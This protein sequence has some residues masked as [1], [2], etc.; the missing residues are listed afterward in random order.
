MKILTIVTALGKG[1][2][3]RAAQNFALGY[4]KLGNDSRILVIND[5][6]IRYEEIKSEI[7]V[8]KKI[9]HENLIEL[10]KWKLD[11]I[12]IHSHGCHSNEINQ[13]FNWLKKSD[14]I[15]V[16][17]NVFSKPSR[18]ESQLHLSFQ[19][20]DWALKLYRLRNGSVQKS[21]YVPYPV[22]YEGF[23]KADNNS[24]LRFKEKY[25]I[26]FD[27]QIIGRIGQFYD[28]KWSKILI[29]V[30]FEVQKVIPNTTL[31]LVNAPN[32][33]R[34]QSLK[35]K[36]SD[37][38]ILID[39]LEGDEELSIAYS[40][41]DVFC[42]TADQGESF[43]MVITE[44]ILCETPIVVLDTPWADNTQCEIVNNTKSGLI[45]R[46]ANELKK[47]IIA[48]LNKEIIIDTKKARNKTIELFDYLKVAN[49][50]LQYIEK[51]KENLNF[52][53]AKETQMSNYTNK[54][55]LLLLKSKVFTTL[56]FFKADY[57][58]RIKKLIIK[59][60]IS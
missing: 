5:L 34:D 44:S 7:S 39:Q 10:S 24:I 21:L 32:S 47:H 33:I 55:E 25:L 56:H 2:T 60:I 37:K 35:S 49:L 8:Y 41:F 42:L 28:G 6:G 1:G 11:V 59:N 29:K 43:G 31:V 3:E 45:G 12:H 36:I 14:V 4:K 52:S 23:N 15:V 13:L 53:K 16:E 27:T 50:S 17:T 20:S 19:L 51:A 57:L 54:V 46:N 58:N 9:T 40:S 18:W 38:I 26:P 30:F 48:I 22:K